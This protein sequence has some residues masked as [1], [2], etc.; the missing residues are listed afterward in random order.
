MVKQEHRFIYPECN[1]MFREFEAI[2]KY[3]T[4][5][6]ATK[7]EDQIFM[8]IVLDKITV[9]E[10]YKILVA[11]F[12][13]KVMS[14]QALSDN[15]LFLSYNKKPDSRKIHRFESTFYIDTWA[16]KFIIKG[17]VWMLPDMHTITETIEFMVKPEILVRYASAR[18]V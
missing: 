14:A 3:N 11:N 2:K 6:K 12:K 16:K 18:S 15:I 9:E 7:F 17:S 13:E 1:D 5:I 4:T 10:A 8:M